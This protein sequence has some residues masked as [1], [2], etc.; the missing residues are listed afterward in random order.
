MFYSSSFVVNNPSL[1]TSTWMSRMNSPVK[2]LT[3]EIVWNVTNVIATNWSCKGFTL[4]EYPP[5]LFRSS[6]FAGAM[7]FALFPC[8][9]HL[10]LDWRKYIL[11]GKR[12]R[13]F[14]NC[15]WSKLLP[16]S[17]ALNSL[18]ATSTMAKRSRFGLSTRR[19]FTRKLYLHV[20][21]WTKESFL[22]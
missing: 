1:K 9:L 8:A 19:N 22:P 16:I 6:F 12:E 18:L 11:T 7:F 3:S 10:N 15:V 14:F 17:S 20:Y 2:L 4:M 21:I 13:G 5:C